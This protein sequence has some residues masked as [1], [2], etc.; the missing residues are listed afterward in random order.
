MSS[1]GQYIVGD[2]QDATTPPELFEYDLGKNSL[3]IIAKLNPQL[4]KAALSPYQNIHW[5][6]PD[7]YDVSG[8]LFTP[9]NY[10]RDTRYPL[11]IQT[12]PYDGGFVCDY[13]EADY[14]SF[15]PQPIASSGMMYLARTYPDGWKQ[16]DDA[17]HYPKGYP[18]Q[19]SEAAFQMSIWDNAVDALDKR[20]MIDPK[21]VGIIGFSRSGWYTEFALAHGETRYAAAT[22]TD[23]VQYS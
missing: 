10:K 17:A 4:D 7:G 15:A 16:A 22:A 6:M 18:G 3:R 21:K 12:K 8:I 13:G 1:N 14:P 5:T 11:V 19:L 23:N 2:Y 9:A 20:G